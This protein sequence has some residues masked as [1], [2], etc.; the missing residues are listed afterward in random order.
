MKNT[1]IFGIFLA[2]GVGKRLW[3]LSMSNFSKSLLK[4]RAG[5][6]LLKLAIDSLRPD[7]SKKGVIIVTDKSKEKMLKKALKKTPYK[8]I[9]KEPFPMDTASAIGVG[10]IG[11]KDS[12]VVVSMPTDHVI[13]NR[14]AFRKAVKAATSFLSKKPDAIICL[15]TKP[16]Y[17]TTSYGYIEKGKRINTNI[18]KISKFTEKP[19]LKKSLRFNRTRRY[20]WNSGIF[21]FTAKAYLE[22]LKKH[23]PSL[24]KPLIKCKNRRLSIDKMYGMIKKISVDYLI[25]EKAKNIYVCESKFR[26]ID[27]GCW[28]SVKEILGK[29]RNN[30][31]VK[32]NC[33]IHNVK[34]SLIYNVTD[35]KIIVS[36]MTNAVVVCSDQ[37]ILVAD[38]KS[39]EALKEIIR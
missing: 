15:G 3:P 26:W 27:I 12:D 8:K 17:P 11:L 24:Y 36:G 38:K 2:G 31:S 14:Q 29:D 6:T 21:V 39:S 30:N 9:I 22:S 33:Q 10:V 23:A 35:K 20:L 13:T 7:L 34:N 4:D 18:I 28:N 1:K 19:S 37:G 5:N 32:G 25:L 16:A